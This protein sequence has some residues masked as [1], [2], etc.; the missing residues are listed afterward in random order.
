VQWDQQASTLELDIA[1][2]EL[3]PIILACT[4]WGHGWAGH[5]VNCHCDNQVVVACIHSRSSRQPDIMYML[6]CLAF[7]EAK[8]GF[9]VHPLYINTKLNHL[10]D[11]L[12]RNRL[13]SFLSKVP[14]ANATPS[15][16]PRGLLELLLNRQADWILEQW[17]HRFHAIFNLA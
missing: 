16:I 12:S 5:R 6:R 8:L 11:D 3:I 10:A 13:S 15:P 7:V 4:A 9:L 2:K 14:Q 1:V 17:H